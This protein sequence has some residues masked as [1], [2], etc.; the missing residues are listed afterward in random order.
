MTIR[1][2]GILLIVFALLGASA[3]QAQTRT[4]ATPMPQE[5]QAAMKPLDINSASEE[6]VAS[7]GIDRAIA[8][9]IVQSR[10]YRS[11]LELVSRQILTRDQ[12]DKLKDSLVAKQPPKPAK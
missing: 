2:A 12:Y 8:K 11:K 5:K 7:L 4:R 10:P 1:L 3:V 9:K 6:E